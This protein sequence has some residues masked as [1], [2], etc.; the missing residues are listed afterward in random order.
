MG[1]VIAMPITGAISASSAGW[2]VT[3]YLYGGLGIAWTVVWIF[4]GSD[5]P[6]KHKRISSE[7]RRYVEDGISTEEK[8]VGY[9]FRSKIF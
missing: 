3:F 6:S 4:F 7:E 9:A 5:S 8:E 1:N 2:P